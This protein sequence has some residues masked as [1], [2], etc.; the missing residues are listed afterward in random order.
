M[1]KDDII[2]RKGSNLQQ[3]LN[4]KTWKCYYFCASF[5]LSLLILPKSYRT[6]EIKKTFYTFFAPMNT[7]H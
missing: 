2:P 1:A 4:A 6:I 5:L 7:E 3:R